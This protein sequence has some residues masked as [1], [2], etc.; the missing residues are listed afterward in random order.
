MLNCDKFKVFN[1]LPPTYR[2]WLFSS[3]LICLSPLNKPL[4]PEIRRKEIKKSQIPFQVRPPKKQ[5][6]TLLIDFFHDQEM[7]S[8][9]KK[10]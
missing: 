9:F 7:I 6:G 4:L 3:I 1:Q 5:V 2:W 8:D 10:R